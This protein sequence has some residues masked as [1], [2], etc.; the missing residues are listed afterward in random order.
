MQVVEQ[1]LSFQGEGPSTG[2]LAWFYRLLGCN[3]RCSWCD[4]KYSWIGDSQQMEDAQPPPSDVSLVVITGGEPLWNNNR[5]L[6]KKLIE[7]L[8]SDLFV[9]IETN[10]SCSP[11]D[12]DFHLVRSNIRYIVSPKF[13]CPM[14]EWKL[15]E[16]KSYGNTVYKFV[17]EKGEELERI[18]EVCKQY[19]IESSLVWIQPQG[20]S[21]ESL[22]KLASELARAI[23][24]KKY[25]ISIRL[26]YLIGCK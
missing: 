16:F 5:N 20:V 13:C 2:C 7:G 3:L 18:E 12:Q 10:G 25:N 14:E 21:K 8:P 24:V 19:G 17:V 15:F 23:L 9:E 11:L 6:T 4:T 26:H 22:L 1:F